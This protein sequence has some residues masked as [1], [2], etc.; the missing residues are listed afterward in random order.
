M[1]R[2]RSLSDFTVTSVTGIS[3]LNYISPESLQ[4]IPV[5]RKMDTISPFS[6]HAGMNEADRLLYKEALKRKNR[7]RFSLNTAH[8]PGVFFVNLLY[9]I[10]Q[11]IER[12]LN[13]VCR[14]K[15][16][17]ASLMS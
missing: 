14:M 7:S 16:C 2:I 1:I 15:N 8:I 9:D 3:S 10:I 5:V 13:V 12:R 4:T 11:P 17:T 6:E